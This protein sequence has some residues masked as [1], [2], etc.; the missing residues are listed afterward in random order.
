[1]V[2][3]MVLRL[4]Q[5]AVEEVYVWDEDWIFRLLFALIQRD[6]LM[7]ISRI[8]NQKLNGDLQ[9]FMDPRMHM[10]GIIHEMF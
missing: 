3:G 7:W 2:L 10:T 5:M 4:I 8:R 6:T 9:V 1:M